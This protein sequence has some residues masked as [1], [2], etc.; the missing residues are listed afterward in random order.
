MQLCCATAKR[1]GGVQLQGA[2]SRWCS[3][4]HSSEDEAVILASSYIPAD[5]KEAV[6]STSPQ[7]TSGGM[8]PPVVWQISIDA[9]MPLVALQPLGNCEW[10]EA[11]LRIATGI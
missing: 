5:I 9:L 10:P 7:V 4:A 2:L 8:R 3:S 6:C 1:L 11:H